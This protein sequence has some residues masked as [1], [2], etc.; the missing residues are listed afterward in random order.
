LARISTEYQHNEPKL[1]EKLVVFALEIYGTE[2]I[3]QWRNGNFT[4]L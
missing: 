2:I 4:N 3:E 1:R